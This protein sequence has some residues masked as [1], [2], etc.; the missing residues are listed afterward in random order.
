MTVD[1]IVNSN[2]QAAEDLDVLERAYKETQEDYREAICES[3]RIH[4]RRTELERRL[5]SLSRAMDDARRR[6]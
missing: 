4:E 3:A 1:A 5:S 2:R 6:P